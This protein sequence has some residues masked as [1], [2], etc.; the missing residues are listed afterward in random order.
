MRAIRLEL[1]HPTLRLALVH[2][3]DVQAT[4]S[5]EPLLAELAH[6]EAAVREDASRFAE[7]VR[8]AVRDVLRLGGYKPTGRGKPASEFL[9]AQALSGGLPRILN[10]VDINNLA[11]LRHAHPISVFDADALGPELAVRF[12]RAGE[13]YVF[14][15]SGQ[16]MEIAGLPVIAR[17]LE[18]EP[19]GNPVKDSM[20]CKVSTSTRR[21]LYVV[22][23][24]ARLDPQLLRACAAELGE[25]L[26]RHAGARQ[27]AQTFPACAEA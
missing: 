4:P 24:S 18:R 27:L 15:P 1:D 8:Q 13:R 22:Y 25:L 26:G 2:A 16:S 9:L 5:V 17:G 14:N 6:A 3:T 7:P 19:V 10:L 12:G 21:A 20:L 11:S 23:G